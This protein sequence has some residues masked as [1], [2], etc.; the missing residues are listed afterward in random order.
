[1]ISRYCYDTFVVNSILVF[2]LIPKK[3]ALVIGPY[4]CCKG[5]VAEY[6]VDFFLKFQKKFNLL[7][8]YIK[9]FKGNFYPVF[10]H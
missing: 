8:Q 1:M 2:Y 3:F 9:Y 4:V 10:S 5:F 7:I 6:V